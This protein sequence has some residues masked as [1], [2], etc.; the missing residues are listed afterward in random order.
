MAGRLHGDGHGGEGSD[1]SHRSSERGPRLDT[2]VYTVR[3]DQA[4]LKAEAD[5]LFGVAVGEG[6]TGYLMWVY[7]L[8][9]L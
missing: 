4:R 2:S 1:F 6:I 3:L 8:D 5:G 9:V 7:A